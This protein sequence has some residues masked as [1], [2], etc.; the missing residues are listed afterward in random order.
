MGLWETEM[1]I[2]Q[3]FHLSFCLFGFYYLLN[4]RFYSNFIHFSTNVFFSVSEPNPEYH[5]AFKLFEYRTIKI[6]TYSN[7]HTFWLLVTT[8]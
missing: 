1:E 5:I 3:F 4:S 7:K 8:L 2:F 6:I